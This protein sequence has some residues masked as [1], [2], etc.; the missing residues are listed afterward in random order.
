VILTCSLGEHFSS[1]DDE[2]L[3][4]RSCV[5]PASEGMRLVLLRKRLINYNTRSTALAAKIAEM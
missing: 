5:R 1:N 4:G 3:I 2:A